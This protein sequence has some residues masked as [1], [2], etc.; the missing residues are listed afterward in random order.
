MMPTIDKT[1][2][3]HEED[4]QNV[5][6]YDKIM[7]NILNGLFLVVIGALSIVFYL[8]YTKQKSMIFYAKAVVQPKVQQ[9]PEKRPRSKDIESMFDEYCD[10]MEGDMPPFTFYSQ[11]LLPRIKKHPLYVKFKDGQLKQPAFGVIQR[12]SIT[13]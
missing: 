11:L 4:N 3:E 6:L 8:E 5:F 12:R 9:T 7:D 2:Y 10:E 1:V 13:E